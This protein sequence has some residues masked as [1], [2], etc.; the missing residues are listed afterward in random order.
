[1][2]HRNGSMHFLT[3]ELEYRTQHKIKRLLMLSGIRQVKTLEQFD[4]HFNPRINKEDS[5]TFLTSPWIE[6]A[7]NLVSRIH[8]AFTPASKIE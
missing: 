2:D 8:K 1:P 3:M 4:W 7:F 6:D 5:M